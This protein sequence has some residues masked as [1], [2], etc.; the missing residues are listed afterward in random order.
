MTRIVLHGSWEFEQESSYLCHRVLPTELP[1]PINPI[2]DCIPMLSQQLLG[3]LRSWPCPHLSSHAWGALSDPGALSLLLPCSSSPGPSASPAFVSIRTAS[4]E[5]S[6]SEASFS[7]PTSPLLPPDKEGRR[8][9]I[10]YACYFRW[11]NV[12]VRTSASPAPTVTTLHTSL[13]A[14]GEFC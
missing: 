12:G 9:L 8:F 6:I 11:G 2:Y 14:S 4:T 5:G 10:A 7:L 13:Q 3:T 1:L